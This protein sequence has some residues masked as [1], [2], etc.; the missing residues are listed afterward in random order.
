[1]KPKETN[2]EC[3]MESVSPS[4]SASRQRFAFVQLRRACIQTSRLVTDKSAT[5]R[6]VITT[7][8]WAATVGSIST[9]RREPRATVPPKTRN[10]AR[11]KNNRSKPLKK[12]I[13]RRTRDWM[14]SALLCSYIV[15][16][17]NLLICLVVQGARL[18]KLKDALRHSRARDKL[19]QWW[20]F[21]V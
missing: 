14:K 15:A 10:A 16:A 13:A 12:Y 19:N 6:S 9:K 21:G 5:G 4:A 1:M 20:M 2:P 17:T 7:G 3:L 11:E 8:Q 18:S